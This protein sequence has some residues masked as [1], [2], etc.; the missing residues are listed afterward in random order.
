MSYSAIIIVALLS[1]MHAHIERGCMLAAAHEMPD[2]EMLL[3]DALCRMMNAM[4][5]ETALA[6]CI[7][8]I[9]N[10]HAGHELFMCAAFTSH[11]ACKKGQAHTTCRHAYA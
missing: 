10:T 3:C 6:C 2:L 1:N 8:G 5:E 7:L 11:Y 9:L 4:E